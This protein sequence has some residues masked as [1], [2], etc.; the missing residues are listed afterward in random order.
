MLLFPTILN[1]VLK[2]FLLNFL[3]NLTQ[4]IF[5]LIYIKFII[6]EDIRFNLIFESLFLEERH[7]DMQPMSNMKPHKIRLCCGHIQ[8]SLLSRRH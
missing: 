2:N 3:P 7:Q 5:R 4:M 6:R 8:C 1:F